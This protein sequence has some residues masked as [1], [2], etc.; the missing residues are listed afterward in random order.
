MGKYN[1]G[2]EVWL[3]ERERL[4]E[5]I[6]RVRRNIETCNSQIEIIEDRKEILTTNN[7]WVRQMIKLETELKEYHK[8]LERYDKEYKYFLKHSN[9]ITY[10]K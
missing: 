9:S 6:I 5:H 1:V 10:G 7:Y 2:G 8:E 3:E 4:E